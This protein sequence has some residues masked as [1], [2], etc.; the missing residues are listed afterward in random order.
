MRATGDGTA[1]DAPGQ[2]LFSPAQDARRDWLAAGGIVLAALLIYLPF[3]SISLDDFDSFNFVRALTDF[4]PARFQPHPPGYVLYV[5]LGRA[6][7]ALLGNPRL[8]LTTLSAVSAALACGLLYATAALLFDRRSGLVAVLFVIATPLMWLNAGKAL[9]DA[10]GLC[11]QALGGL[12]LALALRRPTAARLSIAAGWV[13]VAA[14]FRPQAVLGLAA[15]W[16]VVAVWSRASWRAWTLAGLSAG[17]GA[18]SWLL[19]TLA[20]FAWNVDALRGYMTGAAGFVAGQESLFATTVTPQSL[21]VRLAAVWDWGSQA[22][23]GPLPAPLRTGLA[24]GALVLAVLPA[25]KRKPSAS[26]LSGAHAA[27]GVCIAWL[28]PQAIVQVLFLNPELTRYLLA[29]LLPAA[30][31]AAAGLA[32][33]AAL[34][35]GA[36]SLYRYAPAA[37]GLAFYTLTGSAA[38]PLAQTLHT[39]PAP[40]DQLAAYLARRLPR[41]GTFILARQSYNAL[42]YELPGWTVRFADAYAPD[43]VPQLLAASRATYIV[44]ADPEGV[45]PGESYVQIDALHFSRDPQ[46]HAKHAAVDANLYGLAS[47][48]GP[49]EFTLPP[50]GMIHI[51]AP[52]AGKYLLQGWYRAE[53]IGGVAARWT[54]SADSAALRVLLPQ[55]AATLTMKVMSF[56]PGQVIA[57]RCDG[58]LLWRTP[59]YQQWTWVSFELPADCAH[60]GRPTVLDFRPSLRRAPADDGSSTDRRPLAVAISEIR[61]R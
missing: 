17:A 27:W 52:L 37:V 43:A 47:A 3:R 49:D 33:L 7:L 18:L 42:A 1:R 19:P 25:V 31:L 15:A 45:Q 12:L 61:I 29:C 36:N 40:P 30:L 46:V 54:G 38:L 41:A 23:F 28:L 4:N 60:A 48:L 16:L 8:A 11:A 24:I 2:G 39:V 6:A 20:A 10:P 9:S 56:V 50:D 14:G 22:V 53:D 21:G 34:V 44:I 5:L 55:R 51:G 59:V 13:G 32:Q 26:H 35:R 57:L 58:R